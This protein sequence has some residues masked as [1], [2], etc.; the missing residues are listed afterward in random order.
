MANIELT[1]K[2]G[3]FLWRNIL[4]HDPCHDWTPNGNSKRL[5]KINSSFAKFENIPEEDL[6][7]TQVGGNK[8]K[9]EAK[10]L[11]LSLEEIKKI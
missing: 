1:A 11:M 9:K 8:K 5:A 2:G 7:S 10:D 3:N 4:S 6:D